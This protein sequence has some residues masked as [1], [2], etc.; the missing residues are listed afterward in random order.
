V[1]IDQER[2]VDAD[3]VFRLVLMPADILTISGVLLINVLYATTVSIMEK[4]LR[5][6]ML[7]PGMPGYSVTCR[8]RTA[9]YAK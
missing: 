4:H 1:L 7:V 5:A 3:I 8:T 6:L 2:C 9:R